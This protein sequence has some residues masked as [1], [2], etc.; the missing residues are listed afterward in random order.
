MDWGRRAGSRVCGS[1]S[2]TRDAQGARA[3][4]PLGRQKRVVQASAWRLG[5]CVWPLTGFVAASQASVSHR[6]ALWAVGVRD[7]SNSY[8]IWAHPIGVQLVLRWGPAVGGGWRGAV[9][10]VAG[11]PG[12]RCWGG[13]L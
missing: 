7:D 5:P 11:G 1:V 12:L 13:T 9:V 10:S 3:K 4:V 6:W 8:S 2:A